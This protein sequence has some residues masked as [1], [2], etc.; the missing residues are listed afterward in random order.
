MLDLDL[1]QNQQFLF[2]L[3]RVMKGVTV[4]TWQKLKKE[5]TVSHVSIVVKTIIHRR[6]VS[7][8]WSIVSIVEDIGIMRMSAIPNNF[9]RKREK[10]VVK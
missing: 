10:E 5:G 9:G 2:N 8:I 3:E 6:D 4:H 7:G 1:G